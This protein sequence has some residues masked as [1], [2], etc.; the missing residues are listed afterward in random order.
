MARYALRIASQRN[1]QYQRLAGQLAEP[2]LRLSPLRA[3]IDAV[4]PFSLGDAD[5][6]EVAVADDPTASELLARTLPLLAAT[7]DAFK[8]VGDRRWAPVA[9]TKLACVPRVMAEARRY[10]GKTNELLTRVMVNLATFDLWPRPAGAVRVLD[11]LCGG[12]TTLFAAL[13]RGCSVVGADRDRTAVASTATFVRQFCREERLG[14]REVEARARGRGRDWH[15]DITT[16]GGE[17]LRSSL[18]QA[19]LDVLGD[20]VATAPGGRRTHGV[21]ADLPYGIRHD[22]AATDLVAELL[23]VVQP[24]LVDGGNV[25]LSW[26]ASSLGRDRLLGALDLAGWRVAAEPAHE[27][28]GHRVDRVI[29]RREVLVLVAERPGAAPSGPASG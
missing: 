29:K 1:T 21:V 2:E 14:C 20:A 27:A 15:H 25:V 13:E 11:P 12:G 28:L 19:S 24:L 23:S 4:E 8:I 10:S 5:Y 26:N 17:I 16:A 18:L 22:G 3:V 6:L 7:T 9:V